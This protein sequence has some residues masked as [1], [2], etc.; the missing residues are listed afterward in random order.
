MQVNQDVHTHIILSV[1]TYKSPLY[2]LYEVLNYTFT[3]PGSCDHI[4]SSQNPLPFFTTMAN[5]FC[6]LNHEVLNYA[7]HPPHNN[8]GQ[9]PCT[10]CNS[11]FP[12][13]QALIDITHVDSH[14]KHEESAMRRLYSQTQHV[15][16][17]FPATFPIPTGIET[18][19][20]INDGWFFHSPP[21]PMTMSQPRRNTFFSPGDQVGSSQPVRKMQL[22]PQL[23]ALSSAGNNTVAGRML[24]PSPTPQR[25]PEESAYGGTKAYITQL[26][27]PIKKIDFI[28]LVNTDDDNAE[29]K[30][31]DL[32]LKL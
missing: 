17:R 26:E 18:Q 15:S 3:Y 24:A 10:H 7:Q 1:I 12:S 22:P 2:E 23:H 13:T 28:D 31:L 19:Q 9:N 21:Q 16:H 27:K 14:I 8:T 29:V 20:N 30:P 4:K 32:T 25:K 5:C 11:V 6:N